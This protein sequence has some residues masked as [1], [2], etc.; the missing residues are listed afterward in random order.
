MSM[1]KR[2]EP[3]QRVWFEPE[4]ESRVL[5][6]LYLALEA[7]ADIE[8]MAADHRI[9]RIP[10]R[11]PEP[12]PKSDLARLAD[13][14]ERIADAD[15]RIAAVLEGSQQG[16]PLAVATWGRRPDRPDRWSK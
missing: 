7:G 9:V 10:K 4:L 16:K 3:R 8:A 11:E 15:E 14:A 1:F 13:A 6:G 5:Q 2:R 12:E